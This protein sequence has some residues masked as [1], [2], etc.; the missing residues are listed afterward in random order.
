MAFQSSWADYIWMRGISNSKIDRQIDKFISSQIDGILSKI[1][2]VIW[3][4]RTIHIIN[5]NIICEWL[6]VACFTWKFM[7]NV[8][9]VFSNLANYYDWMC[10]WSDFS[11]VSTIQIWLRKCMVLFWLL[12]VFGITFLQWIVRYWILR[13]VCMYIDTLTG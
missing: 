5:T 10:M 2:M 9:H 6:L 12:S 13:F 7:F 4:M 1:E 3:L 8:V 11:I